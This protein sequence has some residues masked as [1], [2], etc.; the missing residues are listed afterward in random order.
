MRRDPDM[1]VDQRDTGI[2]VQGARRI[3]ECWS[4]L[5]AELARHPS[6]E[7]DEDLH[8]SRYDIVGSD[9]TRSAE[10]LEHIHAANSRDVAW[11]LMARVIA[12]GD[13]SIWLRMPE[14]EVLADPQALGTLERR[15][16]STGEFRTWSVPK[17][18][19]EFRPLWIKDRDWRAFIKI[20][21]AARGRAPSPSGEAPPLSDAAFEAWVSALTDDERNSPLVD[22][23][24][25]C[26]QA[27]PDKHISRDRIRVRFPN[28][29]RGR[30]KSAGK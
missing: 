7:G 28:R 27:F 26:Q 5:S 3:N 18:P 13:L 20:T 17:G 11:H 30:P 15:S 16:F 12:D 23:H 10:D 8:T 6:I 9:G 19:L 29:K 22:L 21:L 25:R 2:A 1:T 24:D 14:G 4:E